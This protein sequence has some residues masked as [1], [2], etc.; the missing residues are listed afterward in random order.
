MRVSVVGCEGTP[1]RQA[2]CR[3]DQI[4]QRKRRRRLVTRMPTDITEMKLWQLE[5]MESWECG[6]PI[7]GFITLRLLPYE[8]R[9]REGHATQCL[10]MQA[11]AISRFSIGVAAGKGSRTR[12][13][14]RPRV[15][16]EFSRT[17]RPA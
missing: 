13:C 7:L 6:C 1:D 12:R 14:G 16:V 2:A 8:D 15:V 4:R 5:G 10:T 9:L 11:M 17:D 3:R